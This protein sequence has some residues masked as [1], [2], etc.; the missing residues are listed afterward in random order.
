MYVLPE[1]EDTLMERYELGGSFLHPPV[2]CIK[3]AP[4]K[5]DIIKT[6]DF[7]PKELPHYPDASRFNGHK[8]IYW[9]TSELMVRKILNGNSLPDPWETVLGYLSIEDRWVVVQ[10][11]P[12]LTSEERKGETRRRPWY[13]S[14]VDTR[15]DQVGDNLRTYGWAEGNRFH[16]G[17]SIQE[18]MDL[19][20]KWDW[21]FGLDKRFSMIKPEKLSFGVYPAW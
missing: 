4:P 10:L 21:Y 13:N 7:R 8:L 6:V 16:Y 1:N 15:G 9:N 18:W 14:R 11:V 12:G 17:Q 3:E 5:Y 19:P 2:H 20:S